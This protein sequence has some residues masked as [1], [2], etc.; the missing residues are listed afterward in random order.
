MITIYCKA[1][2]KKKGKLCA[3]CQEL[4]DYALLK[5]KNCPNL[6]NKPTCEKCPI[7]CY[8]P[9]KREEI[10]KVMRYAGPRMIWKHPILAIAHLFA[11]FKKI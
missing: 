2:H 5:L 3:D 8:T 7:H 9:D 1:H 6:K 4:L 11:R 10:K